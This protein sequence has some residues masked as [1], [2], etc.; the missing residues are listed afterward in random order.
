MPNKTDTEMYISGVTYQGSTWTNFAEDLFD[1]VDYKMREIT[2]PDLW[3]WEHSVN[4]TE[5]WVM[6]SDTVRE[7]LLL[8]YK[9]VK[10]DGTSLFD[11]S[12]IGSVRTLVINTLQEL[13][14][15]MT[16]NDV[17]IRTNKIWY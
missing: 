2:C 3:W 14:S 6:S 4:K 10:Y 11:E 1:L 17:E 7:E 9:D 5:N 8:F 13:S 15:D 12:T 16:F